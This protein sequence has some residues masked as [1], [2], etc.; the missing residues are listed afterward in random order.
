MKHKKILDKKEKKFHTSYKAFTLTEMMMVI[1]ILGVILAIVVPKLFRQ[2]Q[3]SINGSQVISDF[4]YITQAI[5]DYASDYKQY[6]NQL[7]DLNS[8]GYKYLPDVNISGNQVTIDNLTFTYQSSDSN[9]SS[10]PS[11]YVNSLPTESYNEVKSYIGNAIK[12]RL[13]DTNK[14]IKLCL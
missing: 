4:Q 11:L 2:A 14:T 9:C 8:N 10:G 1:L 5:G 12:W 7:S 3:N 6:P 13:D